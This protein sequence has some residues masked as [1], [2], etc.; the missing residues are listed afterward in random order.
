MSIP[1]V[2]TRL[3]QHSTL[4]SNKMQMIKI[5]SIITLY[6]KDLHTIIRH[7]NKRMTEKNIL[8]YH[9]NFVARKNW[10]LTLFPICL[11]T[12]EHCPLLQ[13]LRPYL[14]VSWY[15]FIALTAAGFFFISWLP[16]SPF[17]YARAFV[18]KVKLIP[19]AN[20]KS[21]SLKKD[22]HLPLGLSKS[23]DLFRK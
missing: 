6:I 16:I 22:V 4:T 19:K 15:Y 12:Q 17:Y 10:E 2:L 7:N 5:I 23:F 8:W 20:I 9:P 3:K 21:Q 18:A 1:E 13:V 11:D 14:Y